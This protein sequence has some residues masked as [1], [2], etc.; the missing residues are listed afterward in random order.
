[1]EMATKS[2]IIG[3]HTAKKPLLAALLAG[4]LFLGA[5]LSLFGITG[6]AY[7][8]PLGGVGEFTV[9]F[10]KLN[11]QGFKMYGGMAESGETK[12]TPVFV[13]EIKN[14]SIQGLKISKDFEA[15]GL[16]VVIEA[17]GTV[18]IDGLVQKATQINGNITFGSLTMK[19]NYVGDVQDPVQKAAQ[20][21]TQGADSISIENGDLKTVYLF[22]QKVSLPGMKVYFEKLK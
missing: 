9:Q 13:N 22:Q 21:F 18:S 7:A 5:L 2:V 4:F 6:V 15:L 1:M 3:G 11:G 14:A 20:E 10:D 17:G 12:Q 16:R 8:L 19:E